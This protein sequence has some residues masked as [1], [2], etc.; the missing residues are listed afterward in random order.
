MIIG[1]KASVNAEIARYCDHSNAA[2]DLLLRRFTHGKSLGAPP[3][4]GYDDTAKFARPAALLLDPHRI[5]PYCVSGQQKQ[6]S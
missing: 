5:L 6:L 4:G 1:D 3:S 2:A